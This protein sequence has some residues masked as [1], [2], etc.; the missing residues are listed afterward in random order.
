VVRRSS[1]ERVIA[2]S[3]RTCFSRRCLACSFPRLLISAC[4]A[5]L[6]EIGHVLMSTFTSFAPGVRSS[7]QTP[8]PSQRL[9]N[10]PPRLLLRH[11][12]R[13]GPDQLPLRQLD[14]HAVATWLVM[15]LGKVGLTGV[16]I[17]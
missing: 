2:G 7:D 8:N 15:Q 16:S 14:Q 12:L 3:R 17:A 1:G 6:S 10:S 5:C 13:R 9:Q 4:R 11:L